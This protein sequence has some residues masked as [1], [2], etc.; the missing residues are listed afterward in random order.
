MGGQRFAIPGKA[1][2]VDVAGAYDADTVAPDEMANETC[3]RVDDTQ[4]RPGQVAYLPGLLSEV[5]PRSLHDRAD[6][7]RFTQTGSDDW[8]VYP[9]GDGQARLGLGAPVPAVS[10]P[11]HPAESVIESRAAGSSGRES[12]SGQ[13]GVG[14]VHGFAIGR[15]AAAHALNPPTRL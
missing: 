9:Q 10:V 15:P 7:V 1:A 6:G 3:R 5:S 13:E 2:E 14:A 12:L 11:H 4:A 8:S